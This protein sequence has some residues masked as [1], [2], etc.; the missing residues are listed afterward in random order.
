VCPNIPPKIPDVRRISGNKFH[1]KD[2]KILGATVK[3]TATP[4]T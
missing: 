2:P 1:T 3:Y 4:E